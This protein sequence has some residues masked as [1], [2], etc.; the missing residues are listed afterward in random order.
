MPATCPEVNPPLSLSSSLLSSD[1]A[2]GELE[3][4]EEDDDEEDWDED[5]AALDEDE[6]AIDDDAELLADDDTADEEADGAADDNDEPSPPK[7]TVIGPRVV[8]VLSLP[9]NTIK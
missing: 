8:E 9:C 7:M 5:E 2:V 6:D 4:E 3:S 1:V